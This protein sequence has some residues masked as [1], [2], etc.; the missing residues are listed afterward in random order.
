MS[1]R[2]YRAR[3][4]ERYVE[5]AGAKPLVVDRDSLRPRSAYLDRLVRRHF[6]A[7]RDAAIFDVGCGHG[8]VLDAA[9]RA[10]YAR[11]GGV[12]TSPQQ[13]EAAQ[14]LG[15]PGVRQGDLL[16]AL[17]GLAPES[18]D[19]VVAFDVLE[20]FTKDET[21]GFVDAVLRVLR[22]GGTWLIHVP[23]GESPFAGR[24]RYGD[25]THEQAFTRG[26][27]T[28]LLLASG[29]A[30]VACFEDRPIPHGPRSTVRAL[31]WRVIRLGLRLYLA[32]ETGDSG[33]DAIFSQNLLAVAVKPERAR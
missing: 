32:A 31:L 16:E 9:R 19:M 33:R 29:F 24:I 22:P 1:E 23:N 27:I 30:R 28:Q 10:G 5:A 8:A 13:V 2:R 14:H 15:I 11:L 4:Y 3:I 7:S 25:Y 12:D 6:P 26:S 17:S 18:Q 20:H 21:L